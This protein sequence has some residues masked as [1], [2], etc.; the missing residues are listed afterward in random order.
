L[1]EL[2]QRLVSAVIAALANCLKPVKH[3]KMPF[4]IILSGTAAQ[5]RAA[6]DVRYEYE[7]TYE[8][9]QRY[10]KRG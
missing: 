8:I 10:W 3:L 1:A 7:T 4:L 6:D 2:R 9:R 5:W